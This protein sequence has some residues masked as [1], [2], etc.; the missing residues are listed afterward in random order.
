MFD[1]TLDEDA[2]SGRLSL[3]YTPTDDMLLYGS[4]SRGFKQGGFP[5]IPASSSS[6]LEPVTKETLTAFEVGI[7]STLGEGATQLNGAVYYYDYEDKQLLGEVIDPIFNRLQ[8]LVNIPESTVWGGEIDFQSLIT[9]DLLVTGS[10]SYVDTEVDK[11]FGV[12]I[13]A[14]P[15]DF[16]GSSFPLT[17]EWQ[18]TLGAQYTF[19]NGDDV[20][21]DVGLDVVYSDDTN[22]GYQPAGESL[23]PRL[24]LDSY[25]TLDARI[26]FED[27]TGTWRVMAWGRN[28]TDEDYRINALT[29]VD[30][31]TRTMG[32]PRTYGVTVSYNWN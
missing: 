2:W 22:T 28:L 15:Q 18:G 4:I 23:D 13:N 20:T 17:P 24:D 16:K 31:Y 3:N 5:T 19:Y 26:A 9:T 12:D 6:Q 10:V 32:M 11:Y 14:M 29:L 1:D 8:A 25:T 30:F 7:K 27:N 21:G